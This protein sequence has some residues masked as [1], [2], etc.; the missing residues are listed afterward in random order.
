[1]GSTKQLD[2]IVVI[3]HHPQEAMNI[4]A[5]VR[6]MKNMGIRQLR[7]VQPV[8]FE[9][10]DIL[11]LAHRCDDILAEMTIYQALE[12]ALADLIFVVGTA[13]ITHHKRPLT[14]DIRGLASTL[15]ARTDHGQVGIL[16]GQEDDGLDN[17]ALDHCHL[18]AML[19]SNPAYPALNLA[20]SVLLFLYELR[21]ASVEL[22]PAAT[23]PP[24]ALA[25]HAALEE[26]I[27]LSEELL[28]AIQFFRYNPA[29]VMRTLRQILYR[30]EITQEEQGLLMAIVRKLRRQADR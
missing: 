30:A 4:G 14:Q 26:L 22:P 21:M 19:P 24:A 7:L 15:V 9:H 10:A 8:A 12:D 25:T 17:V 2:Q 13:A 20:Q 29:V 16:F 11:R 5:V 1:M 3:L 6:A 18:V 28:Q 27:G 23:T